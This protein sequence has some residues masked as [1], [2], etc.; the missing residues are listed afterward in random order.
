M[1]LFCLAAQAEQDQV[2]PREDRVDE[3]RND[4]FV[5]ADDAGKQLFARAQFLDQIRA[6]LVFDRD[7]F[8][9]AFFEFTQMFLLVPWLFTSRDS[10]RKRDEDLA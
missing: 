4:C 9:T 2:V 1:R 3:L 5:I 7:A 6:Q 8:V 10:N